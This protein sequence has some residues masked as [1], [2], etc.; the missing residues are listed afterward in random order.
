M[1]ISHSGMIKSKSIWTNVQRGNSWNHHA[2]MTQWIFKMCSSDF[3][4][5]FQVRIIFSTIW[6]ARLH[7]SAAAKRHQTGMEIRATVNG[8]LRDSYRS[9]KVWKNSHTFLVHKYL[10]HFDTIIGCEGSKLKHHAQP[11]IKDFKR[12]KVASITSLIGLSVRLP[13]SVCLLVCPQQAL[14]MDL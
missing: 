14:E 4:W 9:S 11:W 3:E 10:W 12:R 6:F 8:P 1:N 2:W 13:V 7:I 5:A